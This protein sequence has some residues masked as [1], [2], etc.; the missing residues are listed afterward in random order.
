MK[1]IID[2][3]SKGYGGRIQWRAPEIKEGE[4]AKELKSDVYSYGI[5]L[6][7]L[8]TKQLPYVDWVE[9]KLLFKHIRENDLRP[10]IPKT[11]S[12]LFSD[13]IQSCW[14]ADIEKRPTFQQIIDTLKPYEH[15][16]ISL[17]KQIYPRGS[18]FQ[19]IYLSLTSTQLSCYLLSLRSTQSICV[20]CSSVD[21]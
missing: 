16:L 14:N 12:P 2:K 5:I 6:W 1:E 7:E 9:M 15:R 4:T 18:S 21:V 10:E 19:K 20:V 8:I 3:N 17:S 13:L 11:C